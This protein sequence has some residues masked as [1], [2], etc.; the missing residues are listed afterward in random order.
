MLVVTILSHVKVVRV[1]SVV[2]V[3]RMEGVK[4]LYQKCLDSK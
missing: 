4:F 1:V 2:V 3:V